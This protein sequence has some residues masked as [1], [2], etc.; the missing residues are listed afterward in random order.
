MK[1]LLYVGTIVLVVWVIRDVWV[2]GVFGAVAD[3]R[4]WL[5]VIPLLVLARRLRKRS[6]NT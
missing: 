6:V 1:P 4:I 5:L 3:L 2:W